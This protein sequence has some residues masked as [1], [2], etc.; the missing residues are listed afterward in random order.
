VTRRQQN[1]NLLLII[2]CLAQFMVILDVSI[3]NVALPK[4]GAGLNFSTT[5]L[6]WVVNAYTLT[7]S[8]LLMLGGRAAD[9]LGR[10]RVFLVGVGLF[11]FAS[12]LCAVASSKGLLIGGRARQ[13]VGGAVMSPATKAIITT[14]FAEGAERNRALGVWGA[15]AG[16]GGSSGAL[17]GGILTDGLGWPAIFSIN[18]PI[19]I[20]VVLIGRRVIPEGRNVHATRHFDVAGATLVTGGLFAI[21]YGIVRTDALGWGSAGV[22]APLAAGVAL[23]GLFALVEGRFAKAPLVPLSVFRMRQLRGANLAVFLMYSALFSLWFFLTLYMQRVLGF[24]AIEAGL[25]FLP[26]TL[27]V[28]AGSSIA[29]RLIARVGVRP[30]VTAALLVATAGMLL[31]T[32]VRPGGTYAAQVLPGGVLAALALGV[33]LVGSTIAAVQGVP[34]SQSGLASGLLNTSRLM[35]GALGLAVLGTIAANHTK[36]VAASSAAAALTDGYGLAF[37]V[38]AG[39]TAAGALVAAVMLRKPP[40]PEA[41]AE[42]AAAEPLA[43]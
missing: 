41:V 14:S 39:F 43:A 19:G 17:L 25:S 2:V 12:L 18:I 5:G 34:Q 42:E 28:V 36:S 20:A 26:M 35:G 8:G 6:E 13:G 9:L 24:S 7:F 29:P 32:G 11:A 30:V 37:T 1:P 4:I 10:R 22:L 23:I 16:L 3:V 33:A 27:S 31:L 21:T 15:M 40:A 38:G